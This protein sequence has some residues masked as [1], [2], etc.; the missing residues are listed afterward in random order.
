MTQEIEDFLT[1]SRIGVLAVLLKD[2]SPH[3]ATVHYSHQN[4]PLTLYVSTRGNSRKCEALSDNNSIKAAFVIGFSEDDM[5][6]L[7]MDGDVRKA[8]S[9]ELEAIYTLHYK[10]HPHAEQYKDKPE[11][12]FLIFTPTWW[13]FSDYS[14]TTPRF[15]TE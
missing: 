11:T 7:Q 6:T 9:E 3:A 8:T 5:L 4:K 14:G 12:T 13:R 2:G 1:T 10:K 15:V